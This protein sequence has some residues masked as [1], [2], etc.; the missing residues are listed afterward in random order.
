MDFRQFSKN[1]W[2]VERLDAGFLRPLASFYAS[3]FPPRPSRT[4]PFQESGTILLVK[5]S[6]FGSLVNTLPL[7]Q[8]I[9]ARYPSSR[10]LYCTW[11]SNRELASRIPEIDL[12]VGIKRHSFRD[13]LSSLYRGLREIRKQ[14]PRLALDLQAYKTPALTSLLARLSGAQKTFAFFRSGQEFRKSLI[15]ITV[16]FLTRTP[17]QDSMA[18]LAKAAGSDLPLLAHPPLT[19]TDDDRKEFD[20]LG[21]SAFSRILVI[22]PN[23]SAFCLERRWPLLYF[24]E[25]GSGLLER[26]PD[27]AVI[28]TGSD[29]ERE[30]VLRLER[31]LDHPDRVI[32]LAGR[33][34]IGGLLALL[35]KADCFLS[36]DSGPMHLGLIMQ[37][38]TIALF[39]PADPRNHSIHARNN[40]STFFFEG[41]SCS[42]C[43][44]QSDTAPC[45]GHNLCMQRISPSAVKNA[46]LAYLAPEER[47][48]LRPAIST[49]QDSSIFRPVV[50]RPQKPGQTR[51]HIRPE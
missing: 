48:R 22:N 46:C 23:A 18:R 26:F 28:L 42:P 24:S 8:S 47:G 4:Q 40:R 49:S 25:T 19:V 12:V 45:H 7:V 38:P 1:L 10:I 39:G 36:N 21:L 5:L 9:R 41:L 44:H 6:G 16:P 33:L 14:R 50:R 31:I 11:E 2:N 30:Y 17:L 13:F 20:A 29:T 35:E 32:N 34:S 37:T 27:L 51:Q 15:H 43:V 3:L